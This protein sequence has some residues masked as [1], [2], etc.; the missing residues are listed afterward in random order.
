MVSP[1]YTLAD[2]YVIASGTVTQDQPHAYYGVVCRLQD[3]SNYYFFE[4]GLDG[5][6][7][8]GKMWNGNWSMIGMG[9]AKYSS[10]INKGIDN[11][12]Y[13]QIMAHCNSND[14]SL[15]VNDIFVET[16][17]DNTF[18]SGQ[19]GLSASTGDF[20]GMIAEFD[21]IIAEE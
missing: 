15:Y 10:A 12:G 1:G 8:I 18:S 16:V 11:G 2:G 5:Y 7:R 14:L 4:I 13:N 20:P 17:Y 9:A 6:Y 21:Y 19:I 3:A